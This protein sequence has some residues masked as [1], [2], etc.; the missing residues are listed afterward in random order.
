MP[1]P[2]R[3]APIVL[4]LF[5]LSFSSPSQ[6][7]P[8]D[9]EPWTIT[10]DE[11]RMVTY[12]G[13]RALFLRG[14]QAVF[15]KMT[16]TNGTIE[17]DI[18]FPEQRNFIGARWHIQPGGQDYAYF[19]FRPHLSGMPDANQYT[20]VVNGVSGWQLYAGP[21]FNAPTPYAFDSW[22]PVKIVVASGQAEVYVQDMETPALVIPDLLVPFRQGHLGVQAGGLGPAYFANFRVTPAERPPLRGTPPPPPA[23]APPGSLLHWHISQVFPEANLDAVYTLT[24]HEKSW[25]Q[26]QPLSAEPT[27]ITNLAR[28]HARDRTNNTV[29]ARAVIH[30]DQA[31]IAHLRFGFSDRV[32]VYLNDQLLYRGDDGYQT[33]DYRYLGTVGFFDELFLPLRAGRNEVWFAVSED[34]GGWGLRAYL[35]NADGLRVAAE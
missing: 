15:E 24:A 22:M 9:S 26:W 13:Q 11:S 5:G 21:G 19:Y 3:A 4:L 16:F 31:R 8:F 23:P 28:A 18:A 35:E 17:F 14:G 33:R 30:A 7:L 10:A 1:V 20:P 29:F 2:Y 6:S 34:F 12:Q 32:R 25:L 27:G